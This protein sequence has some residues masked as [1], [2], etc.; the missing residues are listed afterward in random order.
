MVRHTQTALPHATGMT[1]GCFGFT[2]SPPVFR[3]WWRLSA[4]HRRLPAELTRLHPRV[5]VSCD[6]RGATGVGAGGPAGHAS[7]LPLDSSPAT[8]S[9]KTSTTPSLKR[10]AARRRRHSVASKSRRGRTSAAQFIGAVIPTALVMV[11]K[12]N[13][14]AS[15]TISGALW[16]GHSS[17]PTSS[18]FRSIARPTASAFTW[19]FR[20]SRDTPALGWTRSKPWNAPSTT[21]RSHSTPA[22]RSR[23]E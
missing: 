20:N 8:A 7:R 11:G 1:R 15:E 4:R 3:G 21:L 19:E 14:P 10:S 2:R 23:V 6:R 22:S 16:E 13:S 9:R 17:F 5:E 12:S 18:P